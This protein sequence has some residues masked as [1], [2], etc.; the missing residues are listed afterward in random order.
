MPQNIL[1]KVYIII[2]LLCTLVSLDAQIKGS[3]KKSTELSVQNDTLSKDSTKTFSRPFLLD[4]IKISKDSL[5]SEIDYDARD[6][7]IMDNVAKKIYLYGEAIVNYDQLSVKAAYIEYD[8]EKQEALAE[9]RSNAAGQKVGE[10][11]F[12]EGEKAFKAEKL[13]YNFRTRKGIVYQATTEEGDLTI[14][15]SRTKFYGT[16][17]TLEKEHLFSKDAIF[18]TC[19]HPE[20]HFGIRSS[21]Q[22]IVPDELAIVGPSNLEIMGIPTPLW[23]PFGL[24]PLKQGERTGLIFPKDYEY[25]DKWGFG[26]RNVGYYIPINEYFDAKITSDIYLRGSWGIKGNVRYNKRY[27]FNGSFTMGFSSYREELPRSIEFKRDNSFSVVWQ[28]NQDAKANPLH[29]FSAS[30]NFQNNQYNKLN[31]NRADAQLRSQYSSTVNYSR[32]FPGKPYTLSGTARITQ[33]TTTKDVTASLPSLTFNLNTIKP[34]ERKNKP[35][36]ESWYEKITFRY[37]GN[38]QNRIKAKD[39]TLFTTKT[40]E[41][42]SYGVKHT[43]STGASFRIFKYFNLVPSAN[44]DEMWYFKTLEKEFD[45]TLLFHMD[46]TYHPIDSTPIIQ[47]DT[48]FGQIIESQKFGFRSFRRYGARLNLSTKLFGTANFKGK[49]RGIRHVVDPSIGFNFAPDY[50]NPNLNYFDT[51]RSDLRD[52]FNNPISYSPFDGGVFGAPSKTGRQM[53]ITYSLGNTIEAK[54]Y[55]KKD[56]LEKKAKVFNKININGNYNFAARDSLHWSMVRLSASTP[57]LKNITFLSINAGWDPYQLNDNNRRIPKLVW[58]K[59]RVPLRFAGASASLSTRVSVRQLRQTL[60]NEERDREDKGDYF[61]DLFDN[62]S[63]NHNMNISW[64]KSNT[65]DTLFIRTNVI[66]LRGNLK[67]SQNWSVRIGRIGYD[68]KSKSLTYPDLGISRDL[69]CW[70]MGFNWQ[71]YN[72]TYSF[73]LQVKPGSLDFIKIPYGQNRADGFRGF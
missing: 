20:P 51:I 12:K 34:F 16:K 5:D 65:E 67:L 58:E 14:H 64:V 31:D 3:D 17:D 70:T 44:L 11:E 23:L 22:K 7:I 28:H 52:E 39:S 49:I 19:K 68:F 10:P 46:T 37:N 53:A 60:G 30:V 73:N 24:F 55:S 61:V 4:S 42:S 41:N 33:N 29:R 50:L 63:L 9:G 40:L 26:L 1:H 36:K 48:T 25:S 27:R 56:S 57:I 21:K 72:G 15:G 47:T 54:Y 35:G 8:F 62:F 69:H 32:N 45:P 66:D 38:L 13:R 59:D 71:P 18:T 2:V 6:S 43:L